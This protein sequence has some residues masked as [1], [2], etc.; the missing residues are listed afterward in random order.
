MLQCLART[1]ALTQLLLATNL[2]PNTN[3]FQNMDDTTLLHKYITFLE[4][5]TEKEEKVGTIK[6]YNNYIR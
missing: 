3:L 2:F 1:P 4:L 5:M 6:K